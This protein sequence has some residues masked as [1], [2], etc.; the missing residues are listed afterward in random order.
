MK[1][2]SEKDL[3]DCIKEGSFVIYDDKLNAQLQSTN[4]KLVNAAEKFFDDNSKDLKDI[5][6][7]GYEHMG[8]I[9]F[10]IAQ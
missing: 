8:P 9:K 7:E 10:P 4:K 6:I 3:Y 1:Y 5:K 2:N